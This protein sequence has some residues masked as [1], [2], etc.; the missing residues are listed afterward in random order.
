MC[1]FFRRPNKS[2]RHPFG[3]ALA[4]T[5]VGGLLYLLPKFHELQSGLVSGLLRWLL[6][7]PFVSA[8]QLLVDVLLGYLP[9]LRFRGI[10]VLCLRHTY[11]LSHSVVVRGKG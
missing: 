8:R 5:S 4:G 3:L 9:E 2:S 1:G 10:G 6:M 7:L 11:G